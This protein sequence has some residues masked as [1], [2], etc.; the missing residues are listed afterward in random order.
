MPLKDAEE[1]DIIA[2]ENSIEL[3][4]TEDASKYVTG[5]IMQNQPHQNKRG[6]SLKTVID[7]SRSLIP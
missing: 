5:N 2:F 7:E 4:Q 3:C 6:L 1:R